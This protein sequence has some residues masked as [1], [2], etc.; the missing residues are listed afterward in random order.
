MKEEERKLEEE[1]NWNGKK[2][3]PEEFVEN[4]TVC[5]VKKRKGKNSRNEN[6][7]R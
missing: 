7:F 2:V 4:S 3:K 1:E 6:K 5:S